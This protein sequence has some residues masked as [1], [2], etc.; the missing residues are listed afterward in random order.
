MTKGK[1]GDTLSIHLGLSSDDHYNWQDSLVLLLSNYS[2]IGCVLVVNGG[3][4]RT[5]KKLREKYF[6]SH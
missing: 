2:G 5:R 1:K 6:V 3:R 4:G